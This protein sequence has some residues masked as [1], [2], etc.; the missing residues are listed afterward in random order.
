[1]VVEAISEVRNLSCDNEFHLHQKKKL[2]IPMVSHLVE[3]WGNLTCDQ[4]F[5]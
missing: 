3:A 4:T 5:F 2:F 1:M